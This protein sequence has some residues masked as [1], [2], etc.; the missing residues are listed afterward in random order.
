MK[1]AGERGFL[2]FVSVDAN[3]AVTLQRQCRPVD[4]L[5][6]RASAACAKSLVNLSKPDLT[7]LDDCASPIQIS[8]LASF[9]RQSGSVKR[10]KILVEFIY[11]LQLG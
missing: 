11:S 4:R 6:M 7:G 9:H 8:V 10:I 2:D 5:A 1:V 3:A